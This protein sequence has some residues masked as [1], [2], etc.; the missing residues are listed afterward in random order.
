MSAI[1]RKH[2]FLVDDEPQVCRAIAETLEQIGLSVSCFD[3]GPDCLEHL[4]SQRCDLLIAD[5]KMPG[6]DG[7][8]L[9]KSARVAAP[10]VPFLIITGYGDV[11]TA[12]QAVKAGA[13]DFIEKPLEK[14]SFAQTVRA[15]MAAN[16]N[17]RQIGKPLTLSEKRV[18]RL[19]LDGKSNREIARLVSRSVRT[20]EVHR[21]HIMHKLGAGNLV[22]LLKLTAEMGLTELPPGKEAVKTTHDSKKT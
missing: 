15:L 9:L 12:V 7:I 8:E 3:C 21:A 6:M 19:I 13:D 20:I 2:V 22:D 17:H 14:K 11:P 10:W 5:W 16:G 1:E 4:S 18:L